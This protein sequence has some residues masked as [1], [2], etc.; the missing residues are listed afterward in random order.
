MKRYDATFSAAM[1][2]GS[3]VVSASTMSA[4][5]YHTFENLNASPLNYVMYPM[6]VVILLCGVVLLVQDKS[7]HD[8][9]V[10]APNDAST[11]EGENPSNTVHS[12]GIVTDYNLHVQSDVAHVSSREEG[13]GRD[14]SGRTNSAPSQLSVSR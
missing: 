4:V 10:M 6:G 8:N 7:G 14:A 1:F 9:P 13:D 12:D 5:H 2:V 11:I 3:F